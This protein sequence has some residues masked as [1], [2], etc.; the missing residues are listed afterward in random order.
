MQATPATWR[1]LLDRGLERAAASLQGPLRR[2]GAAAPTWPTTSLDAAR[3]RLEHVRPDRDHRLV[4]AASRTHGP[5]TRIV[6]SAGP[7]PTPRSTCST[8]ACSRC[9]SA[10]PASCTS[11]ASAS[12]WATS[13]RPE[14]TAER[15]VADPFP[16]ARGTGSTGPAT[17]RA[18]SPDGQLE[19]LGRHRP[20]GQGPRLPHR[21]GRDR[22]GARRAPGGR[23][24]PWSCR[25]R[26]AR[27]RRAARRLPGA[28]GR[29][30]PFD[31]EDLRRTSRQSLA[32][33]HGAAALR[34][35]ARA[36]R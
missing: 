15:F 4:D 12:P 20:P 25:A 8:R 31:D 19:Y 23:A 22:D 5:R 33:V 35:P 26:G 29:R 3:R 28:A 21:A 13:N 11:A 1:L 9:R 6:P 36:S 32:G 14:L 2:R 34:G 10:C 30:A 7:S 18:G 17:W 24:R 27:R 16:T